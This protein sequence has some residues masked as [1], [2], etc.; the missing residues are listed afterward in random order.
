MS[1][2]TE[3][4]FSFML[5][6]PTWSLGLPADFVTRPALSSPIQSGF[7]ARIAVFTPG[8]TGQ[9]LVD[10]LLAENELVEDFTDATG[11]VV[12][13]VKRAETPE[14]WW[15][16]WRLTEGAITTHIRP[17]EGPDLAPDIASAI[18]VAISDA[19]TPVLLLR[20]PVSAAVASTAGLQEI[21]TFTGDGAA[22]CLVRPAFV[23]EGEVYAG[24]LEA[25][26][27]LR[28]GLADGVELQVFGQTRAQVA[29]LLDEIKPTFSEWH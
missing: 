12:H 6:G 25:G 17:E 27:Q 7:G 11:R 13:F 4:G 22:V 9:A 19:G 21:A 5:A 20:R 23:K 15:L 2:M 1:E 8:E 3:V 26:A 14:T 16:I 18:E 29:K 28:A 10:T 24:D